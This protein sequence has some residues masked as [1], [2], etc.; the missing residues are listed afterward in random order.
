MVCHRCI[1]A[2]EKTL[3]SLNIPYSS[4]H[5][6]TAV[7][8]TELTLQEREKLSHSLYEIG[9][10]LLTDEKEQLIETLKT[11]IICYIH[12]RDNELGNTNLSDYLANQTGKEYSTLSK[13]FSR[14]QGITLEKYVI[15]QKVEKTKEL[16]TYNELNISEIAY[17]LG[18]SSVSHLSSQFKQI[19]GLSPTQFKKTNKVDRNH[20][21]KVG[22]TPPL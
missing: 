11:L 17:K 9:F 7:I 10:E 2:V 4:V 21:D 12:H 8:H 16:I 13:I 19:T 1:T 18:Y 3:D 15:L 6:G 14:N 20:L 5:L 22:K